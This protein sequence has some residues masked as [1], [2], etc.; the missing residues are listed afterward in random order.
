MRI[1]I[2]VRP[3]ASVRKVGGTYDGVLLVRIPER[4]EEGRATEAALHAVAD[5]LGLPRRRIRLVRG[6]STRRKLI[7][8]MG[9][10]HLKVERQLA[11]LLG[12]A[13]DERH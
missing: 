5:A 4:A 8:I 12:T 11:E 1:E 7:E 9:G 10:D 2:H 6:G 13:D 3:G